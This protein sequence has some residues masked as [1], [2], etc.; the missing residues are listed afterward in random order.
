MGLVDL[1]GAVCGRLLGP[2][3]QGSHH[4]ECVFTGCRCHSSIPW[5]GFCTFG[6]AGIRMHRRATFLSDLGLQLHQ[7]ADFYLHTSNDFEQ[8]QHTILAEALSK[9]DLVAVL[10][11]AC[12]FTVF[13]PTDAA[14]DAALTALDI[15]K[16]QLL[17]KAD[18]ADIL[19]YHM[20]PGKILSFDLQTTQSPATEQGQT[21]TI[22]KDGADVIQQQQQQL[23]LRIR[24]Q[25]QVRL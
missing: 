17:A 12:P 23:Q 22:T 20:L 25:L 24:L 5:F 2:Y 18:M 16:E 1:L 8:G 14:F 3:L 7:N 10:T 15:T 4:P 19:K 9:V 11:R 6:G 21:V 13:A